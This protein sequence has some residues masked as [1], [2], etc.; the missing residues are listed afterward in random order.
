MSEAD[1]QNIKDCDQA[2]G[3]S[4]KLE[5]KLGNTKDVTKKTDRELL[6]I[7][8]SI[9]LSFK[10]AFA[11]AAPEQQVEFLQAGYQAITESL[12]EHGIYVKPEIFTECTAG[13]INILSEAE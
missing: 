5:P 6:E 7:V 3:I 12:G 1:D 9:C 2:Y 10:V 13:L 11:H 4:D 8:Q